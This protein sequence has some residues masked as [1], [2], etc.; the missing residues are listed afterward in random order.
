M[1]ETP[2]KQEWTDFSWNEYGQN[3]GIY[4][5][6]AWKQLKPKT[7]GELKEFEA[8][9]TGIEGWKCIGLIL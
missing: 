4:P 6:S 1:A 8:I 5:L 2:H 3:S 9:G 7:Q